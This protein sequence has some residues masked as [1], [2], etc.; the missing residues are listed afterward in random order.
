MGRANPFF[1]RAGFVKVGV[2]PRTGKAGQYGP[3]AGIAAD[4]AR[5]SRFSGPVYYVFDNRTRRPLAE[6]L[7]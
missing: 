5:K 1:E 3:R 6:S 2:I 7:T 4:T